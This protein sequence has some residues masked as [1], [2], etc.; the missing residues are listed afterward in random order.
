MQGNCRILQV[1]EQRRRRNNG[2]RTDPKKK[3]LFISEDS[4]IIHASLYKSEEG[5]FF[6]KGLTG[7]CGHG[8]EATAGH[9]RKRNTPEPVI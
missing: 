3:D 6:L 1:P 8:L 7:S 2:F 4:S 5:D 9:L